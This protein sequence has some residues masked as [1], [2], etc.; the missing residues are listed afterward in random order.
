MK[1]IAFILVLV[2]IG[3]LAI[4]IWPFVEPNVMKDSPSQEGWTNF[5][6][7]VSVEADAVVSKTIQME[8][9]NENKIEEDSKGPLCDKVF[10]E[11]QARLVG[12]PNNV[13]LRQD[14]DINTKEKWL[15][16]NIWATWC[17]PCKGEMPIISE[18]ASDVRKK[19]GNLRIMFLSVDED[20][21]LLQRY[22]AQEAKSLEGIFRWV[23]DETSLTRFYKDIDV[24]NPPTLPV[25]ILI[26]P[27]SR[28][29]CVRVGSIGRKEL[30][31]IANLFIF[32]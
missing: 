12:L 21:R 18:W 17:K 15:Y 3:F 22:M 26:D 30:D 24:P 25:Q 7:G 16:V 8:E 23:N 19:G 28:L 11:R 1:L 20:E 32:R 4:F 27:Q 2:G 9:R 29:R 5:R 31:Q 10:D 6:G 14:Q 13:L